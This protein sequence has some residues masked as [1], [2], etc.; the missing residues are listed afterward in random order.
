MTFVAVCQYFYPLY[1]LYR[2]CVG[3][4]RRREK[5]PRSPPI[6]GHWAA[7]KKVGHYSRPCEP[8]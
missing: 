3:V 1:P 8:S 6:Y 2:C 4:E 7:E 5:L